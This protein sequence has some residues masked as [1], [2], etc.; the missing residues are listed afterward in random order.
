MTVAYV[1]TSWVVAIVFG[2]ADYERL[3][4]HYHQYDHVYSSNLLEAELWSACSR[5]RIDRDGTLLAQLHWVV[6]DRPLSREIGQVLDAGYLRGA[7]AWHVACALFLAKNPSSISFL[8]LDSA[9]RG[10]AHALGFDVRDPPP[11][12]NTT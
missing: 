12:L 9:Q 5:E 6:P 8:T 11:V 3:L 4:T 1:D 2:E 7:D 10:V